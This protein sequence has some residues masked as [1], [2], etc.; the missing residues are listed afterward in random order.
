MAVYATY[1]TS[2]GACPWSGFE[3][4]VDMGRLS[5]GDMDIE[6]RDARI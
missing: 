2:L 4:D 1:E 5:I 6:L 3:L